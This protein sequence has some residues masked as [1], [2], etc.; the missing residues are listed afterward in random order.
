MPDARQTGVHRSP[1]GDSWSVAAIAPDVDPTRSRRPV[2]D[3]LGDA[4]VRTF[5]TR[6]SR[7]QSRRGEARLARRL[8]AGGRASCPG[9]IEVCARQRAVW[10]CA[11][12]VPD[13]TRV[14]AQRRRLAVNE[15][16]SGPG[17]RLRRSRI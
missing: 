2:S 14:H 6:S 9:I 12:Y 16:R 17:Q 10:R 8:A 1:T 5:S 4:S 15:L 11:R 7:R 13:R 3:A